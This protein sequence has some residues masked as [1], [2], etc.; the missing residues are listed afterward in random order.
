[1]TEHLPALQVV[2]PL[3]AGPVCVLLRHPRLAWAWAMLV[4]TM[5][6]GIAA[7]L[8]GQVLATG[9]ST[10]AM[11]GWAAPIGITYVVDALNALVLVLVSGVAWFATAW[12]PGSL[13]AEIP[14]GRQYLFLAAWMLAIAGLL[15]ITITGDAFNVF[16]FLEIA[17]LASYVL[18]G[19]GRSPKAL[20]AAFRYLIAGALGGTFILIGIGML[21]QMTGTL[22]MADLA[23]RL[24]AVA[25]TRPVLV[26]FAFVAVGTSLK[27][28]L[29]PLHGWLPGAYGHAPS[30]VSALL[31]GTAT[32][33]FVYV[34]VRFAFGI[35]GAELAFRE[36][37]LG[38]PLLWLAAIGAVVASA[39]AMYQADLKRL[40]AYSSVANIGYLVLAMSM[41]TRA[42][43]IA[44]LLHLLAH[45][46]TKAAMFLAVGQ[47]VRQVGATRLDDLR[48]L[49]HVMPWTFAAWTLGG[50]G[51][52][53]VPLTVGFVSKW[54]ILASLV[55]AGLWPVAA[56]VVVSSLMALVYVGRVIEVAWFHAPE[57]A[58]AEAVEAPWW[59]QVPTWGLTLAAV[60]LGVAGAWPTELA[61]RAAAAV[62]G[63][64]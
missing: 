40:L 4:V 59:M 49:A 50:L 46:V 2:L 15:G 31:S 32:K 1:M 7:T 5:A 34:L 3:I 29:W 64:P 24:P 19:L 36:L 11:G 17:S 21:Y 61:A 60:V 55:D 35:F 23:L 28:A 57:G 53:G 39:V 51:L 52:V 41:G 38:I 44:A 48:G 10:Y 26:G 16:V 45:A 13:D 56:L 42:G 9:P 6:F 14:R 20:V 30:G 47:V 58:L 25:H 18:I 62:L 54:A 8:L 33:V 43:L 22:N 12:L 37:G 63:A 27:L